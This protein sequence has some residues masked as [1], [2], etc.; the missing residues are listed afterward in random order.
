MILSSNN[1]CNDLIQITAHRSAEA[2]LQQ[3]HSLPV[4][5]IMKSSSRFNVNFTAEGLCWTNNPQ[6]KR[7][8][9]H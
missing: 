3:K 2:Y 8:N 6:L 7:Q 4:A 9:S 1:N 5:R